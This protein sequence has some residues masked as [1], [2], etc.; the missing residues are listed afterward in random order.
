MSIEETESGELAVVSQSKG[1]EKIRLDYANL[2]RGG[3]L[4][5]VSELVYR[6]VEFSILS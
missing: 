2:L 3:I 1:N 5:G 4:K 6:T